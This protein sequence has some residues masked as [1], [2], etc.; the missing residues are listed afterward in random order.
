MPE[1]GTIAHLVELAIQSERLAEAL[2]KRFGA[3][4]RN[5]PEVEQFW[6]R[7]AAEEDGH[8]RWLEKLRERAAPEKMRQPAS[9]S[10]LDEARRAISISV[11]SLVWSIRTLQDAYEIASELEHSEMNSVFEFLI[12]YFTEDSETQTFLRAQLTDHVGR[13]MIEFPR[14][15]GT[16]TFRRT[17]TPI[18]D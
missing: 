1:S 14:H 18:E 7:Y 17:I 13:L 2:Y 15:V 8:A 12:S 16:G 10:V 6:V 5:H 11:D 3:R 4:F 9:P